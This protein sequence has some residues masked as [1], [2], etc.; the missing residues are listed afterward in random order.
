MDSTISSMLSN[1]L[2][3]LPALGL[4]SIIGTL[5]G[6]WFK[7]RIDQ[8]AENKRKIREAREQQYKDFLNNLMGFFEG[9]EDEKFKKQF[10]WDVNANASV[11]AS[12]EI[13][14]L[15]YKFIDS[16]DTKDKKPAEERDKLY[17]KLVLAIRKELNEISGQKL[18][19]LKEEEIKVRRLV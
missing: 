11:Y 3:L 15:A 14:R 16:F 9:W 13:I 18:T 19:E 5:F 8:N 4:G 17:A 7:D 10:I 2:S 12:D 6:Y 1:F